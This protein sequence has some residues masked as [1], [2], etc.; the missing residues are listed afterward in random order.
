MRVSFSK[1]MITLF[2]AAVVLNLTLIM[3]NRPSDM[4]FANS[5][6][7]AFELPMILLALM[8]VR[9][10]TP[11]ARLLRGAIVALILTM[12]L[13]K[14]ADIGTYIAFARP[15]N[16][17]VDL[18]FVGAGFDLG[19]RALG[20][21]LMVL[22]LL[23]AA[24][25]LVFMAWALWWATGRW[26][27]LVPRGLPAQF[28]GVAAVLCAVG[29]AVQTANY[30][31]IRLPTHAAATRLAKDHIR[32]Y[33][34]TIEDIKRFRAAAAIDPF[35]GKTALFDRLQ[36]RDVLIVFIESYGRASFENPL[37][38]PTHTATLRQFEPEIAAAGLAARSGW[39]TSPV[40]GGQSWLAH[41]TLE[42]GL[43]ISNQTK[44][45]AMLASDRLTLYD[46]AAASG[47]RT[48]AIMPGITMA[49][50]EGPMQGFQTIL[51]EADLGY[52]GQPFN[53]VTMPDQY[54]LAAFD[55]LISRAPQAG[56]LF[57]Q[58][59]LLSSHAPWVPVPEMVDWSAVGD[60]TIFD[61]WATSGDPPNVVW[62]DKDRVR[63]QY[64]QALDYSLQA[65]LSYV[66][67]SPK[68][69]PLMVIVG[70]HQAAPFVAQNNSKDVPIHLIAPPDV[71][72]LFNDWGWADG[73]IPGAGTP[74]WPMQDFRDAFVRTM[75]S[76]VSANP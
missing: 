33:F 48:A 27:G 57:A 71:I 65:I 36:G 2:C 25:G 55:R 34:T 5:L 31:P 16:L 35:A 38:A 14:L 18:F 23:L 30:M 56:P 69:P 46:L 11:L 64:R 21:P 50:P 75:S 3:P 37:Y 7:V 74:V 73:L 61:T 49:W 1:T 32:T 15:F 19:M 42:S 66:T 54:T 62:R 40:E 44:Y 63:D 72:A 41:S 52:K 29:V 68:Q 45:R 10:N 17:A 12:L 20:A 8:A 6:R 26:V 76:T 59:V 22:A 13:V 28:S 4:L 24:G 60:G 70:D 53:F 51:A 58:I 43:T 9:E 67:R 47:R 39:L